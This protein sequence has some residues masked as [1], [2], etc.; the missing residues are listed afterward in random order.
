METAPNC[1][2][3]VQDIRA[4][5]LERLQMRQQM[6]LQ[7]NKRQATKTKEDV[8]CQ[9]GFFSKM[10]SDLIWLL[11]SARIAPKRITATTGNIMETRLYTY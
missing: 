8:P 1:A 10:Y 6:I 5:R 9:R 7:I 3:A 2:L 11:G 4:N